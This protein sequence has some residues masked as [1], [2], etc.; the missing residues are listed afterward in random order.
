MT[1]L[2]N[3]LKANL[4]EGRLQTGLWCSLGSA[5][6][7]EVLAGAG[8][9]WLLVDGE[10]SPND[11]L[12]ILAQHRAASAYET[13]IVV[14]M[15]SHDPDAVKQFMDSGIRSF[16]FPFVQT[17]EQARELV[18][19]TR[20]PP[21]GIRG[22]SVSQRANRY[23]RVKDY[24]PAAHQ[25]C[26][27]AVQ[28]ESGEAAKAAAEIAAVEGVD[29]VFIG[30]SDLSADLGSMG[31]PHSDHVQAT[32]RSVLE[33]G[34]DGRAVTGVLAPLDD[35]ARRYIDWGARFVA[36]G[37]DLGLLTKHGDALAAR[38]RALDPARPATA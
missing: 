13:E 1:A 30:P 27:I 10:H 2:R 23:G 26:F 12:T 3:P 36:V 22:Y 33:L 38:F 11:L 16:L 17:P 37:S 8:Y 29:A 15:R 19:A 34:R 6:V 25:E 28:I 21:H 7:T 35:D 24:H 14:R 9:D 18:R 31:N 20:Y 32:I 4:A 5:M